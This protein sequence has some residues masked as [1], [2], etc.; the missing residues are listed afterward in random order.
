MKAVFT[1]TR[2]AR[3]RG[4]DRY[5]AIIDKNSARP[6]A[7]YLPQCV[8]RPDDEPLGLLTITIERGAN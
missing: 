7:I 6:T 3:G 5:E 4:G 1:L 2:P 8:T